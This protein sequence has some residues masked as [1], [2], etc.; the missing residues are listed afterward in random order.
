ME[1]AQKSLVLSEYAVEKA[2]AGEF[3][4]VGSAIKNKDCNSSLADE[5]FHEIEGLSVMTKSEDLK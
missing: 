2:P 3:S 4:K 1:T 5:I